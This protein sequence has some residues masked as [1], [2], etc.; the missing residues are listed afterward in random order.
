MKSKGTE[1]REGEVANLSPMMAMPREVEVQGQNA[2]PL[3]NAGVVGTAESGC[4][5]RIGAARVRE[6]QTLSH[7]GS[8]PSVTVRCLER[9]VPALRPVC[10]R[11]TP[12]FR[13]NCVTHGSA[14]SLFRMFAPPANARLLNRLRTSTRL[15]VFVL[16]LFGLKIGAAAACVGHDM[17]D[18]GFGQEAGEY[19]ANL[20]APPSTGTGDDP[21]PTP[22]AHASSCSHGACHQVADVAVVPACFVFM[23]GHMPASG[24]GSRPPEPPLQAQLRPPII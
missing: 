19:A 6:I 24:A 7:A 20:K 2:K 16:L 12:Y 15:A 5:G 3:R 9:A 22:S 11:D 23:T 13:R 10:G 17:A 18:L 4:L 8:Q 1:R 21:V 14:C